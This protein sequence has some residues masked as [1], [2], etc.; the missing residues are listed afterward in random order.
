MDLAKA[1]ARDEDQIL[2]AT[3][4]AREGEV[5]YQACITSTSLSLEHADRR[6]H[7]AAN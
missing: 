4:A 6:L 1:D 7:T 3:A 2:S 5:H